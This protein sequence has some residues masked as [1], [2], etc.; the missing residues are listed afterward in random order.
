V[1]PST[2]RQAVP[3]VTRAD[4]GGTRPRL[5]T[6]LTTTPD[7]PPTRTTDPRRP[8]TAWSALLPDPGS[9]RI[10]GMGGRRPSGPSLGRLGRHWAVKS[11]PTTKNDANQRKTFPLVSAAF[12]A[13]IR[14]PAWSPRRSCRSG[15]CSR[16]V[17]SSW[18]GR[19]RLRCHSRGVPPTDCQYRGGGH[20]GSCLPLPPAGREGMR[21]CTT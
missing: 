1:C 4:A 7:T 2:S 11:H 15:R 12:G 21:A 5:T 6:V 9:V 13:S 14:Q 16:A 18:P 17:P 8:G 19:P 10:G 20:R 3:Q